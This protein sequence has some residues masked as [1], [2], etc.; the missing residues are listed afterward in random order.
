MERY[1][2]GTEQTLVRDPER[3]QGDDQRYVRNAGPFYNARNANTLFLGFLVHFES[4][5]LKRAHKNFSFVN[6]R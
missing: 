5:I 2:G 1:C 4:E 3:P 6:G